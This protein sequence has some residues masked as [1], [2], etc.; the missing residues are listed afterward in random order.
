MCSIFFHYIYSNHNIILNNASLCVYF[1]RTI[2]MKVLPWTFK[3]KGYEITV[4]WLSISPAAQWPKANFNNALLL[5]L[6]ASNW[7]CRQMTVVPFKARW[8]EAALFTIGLCEG[9]SI[10]ATLCFKMK[11]DHVRQ[12]SLGLQFDIFYEILNGYV[13]FQMALLS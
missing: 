2:R 3:I 9:G 4:N 8:G 13:H 7:K 12:S 1:G 10:T 5:P 11:W 6:D